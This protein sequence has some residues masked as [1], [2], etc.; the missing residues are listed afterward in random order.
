M[1]ECRTRQHKAEAAKV[2]HLSLGFSLGA[3]GKCGKKRGLRES[4]AHRACKGV[5][6]DCEGLDGVQA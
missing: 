1:A 2:V 4:G 3:V 5:V 6:M